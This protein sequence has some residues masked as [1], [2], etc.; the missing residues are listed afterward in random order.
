[1][2]ALET[3]NKQIEMYKN[4]KIPVELIKSLTYD[5]GTEFHKYTQVNEVLNCCS[6]F[7]H[8]YSSKG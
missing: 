8:P 5:N 6:Y 1:M 4:S 2:S 3:A 7:A